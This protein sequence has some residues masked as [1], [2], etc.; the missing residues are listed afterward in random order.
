MSKFIVM[1]GMLCVCAACGTSSPVTVVCPAPARN[2]IPSA[3]TMR[4]GDV[5]QFQIPAAELAEQNTRQIRWTTDN[6]QVASADSLSGSVR[7]LGVGITSA[8]AIDRLVASCPNTWVATV[9]VR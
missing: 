5:M 6:F 3:D 4:V 1:I 2:L 8:R 7:A 9:L